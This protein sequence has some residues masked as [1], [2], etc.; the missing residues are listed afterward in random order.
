MHSKLQTNVEQNPVSKKAKTHNN[1]KPQ[2]CWDAGI[3]N[4]TSSNSALKAQHMPN[5]HSAF[6]EPPDFILGSTGPG[7]EEA[8]GLMI[9][10]S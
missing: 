1:N 4:I 2:A 6:L 7:A 10:I 3:T 9:R 8:L 5:T